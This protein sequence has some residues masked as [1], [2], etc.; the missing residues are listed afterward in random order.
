MDSG[1]SAENGKHKYEFM[2]DIK[3][4]TRTYYLAVDTREEM[5]AW[6]DY[7]CST[8]GLQ[9]RLLSVWIFILRELQFSALLSNPYTA[10][11]FLLQDSSSFLIWIFTEPIFEVFS[12]A[13]IDSFIF[14]LVI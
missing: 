13:E 2:F 11:A 6:V 10:Y 9:V 8:C 7:I 1:L 4:P 14:T 5:K 12:R 3:T